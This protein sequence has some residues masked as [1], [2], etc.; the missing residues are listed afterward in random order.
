MTLA[1]ITGK[2]QDADQWELYL[3]SKY[4]DYLVYRRKQ[5]EK[6]RTAHD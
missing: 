2:L 3:V 4:I 6:Q 5:N 1:E